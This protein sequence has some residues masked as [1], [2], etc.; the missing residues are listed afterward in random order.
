MIP[1]PRHSRKRFA[2]A[3]L[4]GVLALCVSC[5]HC[6]RRDIPHDKAAV[7]NLQ[8]SDIDRHVQN[9]LSATELNHYSRTLA[10]TRVRWQGKILD[11]DPDG[12]VYMIVSPGTGNT[13]DAQFKV[14]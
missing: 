7:S 8:F 4:V 1:T 13:P 11:I 14:S 9:G 6:S 2:P 5:V 10:G 12:T 3:T